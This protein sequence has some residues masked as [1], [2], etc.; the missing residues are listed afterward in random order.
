MRA[1]RSVPLVLHERSD[2]RLVKTLRTRLTFANVMSCLA[3][4]VALG[5]L[6]VAAGLP[7]NSVGSKQLK[8]NSVITGKIKNGAVTGAK[9]RTSTLGTVPSAATAHSLG[10]M[11]VD[12]I[13]QGLKLRCPPGMQP[14]A[15]VCFETSLQEGT[16]NEA[17][18]ICGRTDR[19]LPGVGELAAFLL[20]Q[21][22]ETVGW[23]GS[24]FHAGSGIEATFVVGGP[25]GV[26][27]GTVDIETPKTF[28]CSAQ[29]TN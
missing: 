28:R 1:S 18:N 24:P 13:Q 26:V 5:G 22:G 17:L 27:F 21:P 11:S 9:V 4:F 14:A 7:K 10:G 16:Y 25:K 19:S 6:A 8:P 15:G 29:P 20:T 12:Q 3:L 23:A 2:S